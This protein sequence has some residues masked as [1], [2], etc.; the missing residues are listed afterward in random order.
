MNQ[1]VRAM[2]RRPSLRRISASMTLIL[3]LLLLMQVPFQDFHILGHSMEPT[4]HDQE[5]IMINKAAYFFQP[6]ARGDVIVFQNP[7]NRRETFVKRIIATPGDIISIVGQKVI[8]DDITLHETYVNKADAD[9]PYAPIIKHIIGPNQYFVMG[10]NRGNSSDSRVWGL[11]PRSNIL[12]KAIAIYWPFNVNN[13]GLLP[14]ASN[15]FAH[16]HQ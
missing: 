7:L 1:E 10:D 14:D 8:V 9:N 12:G 5:F 13:F 11:V 2:R 4:L 15:I 6:P 3:I 16:V